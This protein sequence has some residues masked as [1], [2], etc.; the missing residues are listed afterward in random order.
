[1]CER[2]W[3]SSTRWP[4]KVARRSDGLEKR[5]FRAMN[6]WT[7]NDED[8]CVKMST[9]SRTRAIAH[10]PSRKPFGKTGIQSRRGSAENESVTIS[11]P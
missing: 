2:A 9:Y 1:M 6:T 7:R 11:S 3:R 5:V 10:V 4:V 8:D